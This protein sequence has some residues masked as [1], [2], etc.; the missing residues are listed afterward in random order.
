MGLHLGLFLGTQVVGEAEEAVITATS[1]PT[2][3]MFEG[4]NAQ[5]D[6]DNF[7]TFNSTGNYSSTAGT[8]STVD[9]QINGVSAADDATVS[10]DDVPRFLVTDSEG[11]TRAFTISTVEYL[12][13]VDTVGTNEVE[14]DVNPNAPDAKILGDIVIDV[15]SAYDATY[16]GITAGDLRNAPYNFGA[17]N[18]AGL[19]T[20][21]GTTGLGDTLTVDEG[22][23]STPDGTTLTFS[24]QW[25]SDGVDISGATSSTFDIT[26]SEQGTDVTCEVTGSDGA[27]S[28]VAETAATSIPSATATITIT[29]INSVDSTA[30]NQ[31]THAPTFSGIAAVPGQIALVVYGYGMFGHD[32][33][34][35]P[36]PLNMTLG[37]ASGTQVFALDDGELNYRFR[38]LYGKTFDVSAGGDYAFSAQLFDSGAMYWSG[39]SRRVY[40]ISKSDGTTPSV[41]LL[42]NVFGDQISPPHDLS[43]NVTNGTKLLGIGRVLQDPGA[44]GDIT[45]TGL[46][47]DSNDSTVANNTQK[48][49]IYSADITADETPRTMSMDS[50]ASATTWRFHGA[51]LEIS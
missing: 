11:N 23:W 49:F 3:L 34:D 27:E 28:T 26:A 46:T 13:N 38:I 30:V 50:L 24:Y 7:S 25:Q 1:T 17:S 29:E 21:S 44:V 4:D 2:G 5:D 12:V 48:T 35:S 32:E 45:L 31:N 33:A 18:A 19:P 9:Y 15:G 40:L 10:E 41:S 42:S 14:L 36:Y 16:T 20:I 47:L 22:L 6:L 39:W 8:I 51:L 37:G 43:A